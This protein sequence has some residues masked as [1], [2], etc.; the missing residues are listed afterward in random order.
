MAEPASA[1]SLLDLVA[2]AGPV[3]K[4]V[5]LGLILASVYSWSVIFS[6]WIRFKKINRESN[7][8]EDRFWSGGSVNAL[9]QAAVSEWPDS[10][11]ALVFSAGF[12]E[13][14]RW[15]TGE[16]TGGSAIRETD[17]GDL[18]DS[19][20]RAM[21]ATLN[22]EIDQLEQ[23]LTFLATVGSTSPFV[24]LFGTVWG[25][26]NAFRGLAGAKTTT[27]SMVA[28]GIAEALI[29]T[30]IGLVAAIPAVIAYNKYSA[31]LRRL[32]QKI[33]NFGAEFLN[34]L[35]RRAARLKGTT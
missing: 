8:F 9:H 23:G 5:M 3:V 6:K 15:E 19:V 17:V 34:I 18:V 33:D 4:L 29:A 16:I 2:Q 28:P 22:R 27:L 24:G 31:D 7:A 30:A 25:I 13:W 21:T 32:H 35:E 10:P 12:R 20:R 11:M 14:R 1:H 26:M